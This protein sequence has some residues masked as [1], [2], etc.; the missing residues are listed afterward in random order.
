MLKKN[1]KK[2]LNPLVKRKE[3]QFKNLFKIAKRKISRQ[4]F[5]NYLE[6]AVKNGAVAKK[7]IGKTTYYSLKFT[8]NEE[9][10]LKKWL[11]FISKKIDHIPDFVKYY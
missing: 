5:V 11:D 9:E 3:I 2:I 4:T 7:E 1:V 6:V 8:A 10:T